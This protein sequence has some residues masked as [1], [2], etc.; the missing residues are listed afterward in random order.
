MDKS[1]II[2]IATRFAKRVATEMPVR[3]VTLFGSQVRGNANADS[4]IDVAVVID[5]LEGD[6]LDTAS[7]LHRLSR[8]IDDRIEPV[9]IIEGKDP[10]G[11]YAEIQRTGKDV[12]NNK[13]STSISEYTI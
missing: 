3:R 5:K 1:S 2:D 13:A 9:L 10:S 12:Y 11:F 8:T 7:L 6:F 4:D